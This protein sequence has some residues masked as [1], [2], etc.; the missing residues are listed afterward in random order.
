M[1]I[2]NENSFEDP[3]HTLKPIHNEKITL[4][5]RV[6]WGCLQFVIV[7]FPD[8]IHL[9]FLLYLTT[10][11]TKCVFLFNTISVALLYSDYISS[12]IKI[13]SYKNPATYRS[14][15][16]ILRICTICEFGSPTNF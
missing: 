6:P 16:N 7:V 11:A 1:D 13:I 3:K 15:A 9:L 5:L 8:H 2:L 10:A 12:N 4:F 14:G